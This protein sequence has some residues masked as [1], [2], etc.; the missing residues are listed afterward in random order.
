VTSGWPPPRMCYNCPQVKSEITRF[1]R[2]VIGATIANHL[3]TFPVDQFAGIIAGWETHMG[4]D[5]PSGGLNG[6]HALNNLNI[7]T[8][9]LTNDKFSQHIR[10][11]VQD[12]INLWTEAIS[13]GG[14]PTDK[15]YSHVNFPPLEGYDPKNADGQSW[16]TIVNL[17]PQ[18]VDPSAAF[19]PNHRPGFSAYPLLGLLPQI[20]S[21]VSGMGPWAVTEGT[22]Q[23]PGGPIGNSTF[24]NM[25][26]YIDA[27]FGYNATMVNIFAFEI[28]LPTDPLR[29]AT[30]F[31]PTSIIAYLDFLQG[32]QYSPAGLS[33]MTSQT[34]STTT[35]S[36]SSTSQ[37]STSQSS[38]TT[39]DT[40]SNSQF[41][42]I[43][44]LNLLTVFLI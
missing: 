12:F 21:I 26:Q 34:L 9:G 43:V 6:F 25:T 11:I 13:A 42:R 38:E 29:Y 28:G 2:D 37:S 32:K 40:T 24:Q 18:S 7:S 41:L 10:T 20:Q 39:K 16:E 1:G 14:V 36:Q 19:G 17:V 33:S 22:N 35:T 31:N 44:F 8:S 3:K 27:A 23:I 5:Y 30:E 4:S 15:I